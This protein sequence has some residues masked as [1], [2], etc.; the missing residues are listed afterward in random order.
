MIRIRAGESVVNLR[1]KRVCVASQLAI[2]KD[3]A[4]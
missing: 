3:R 1:W 2:H 4:S